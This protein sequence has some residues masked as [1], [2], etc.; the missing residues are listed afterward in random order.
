MLLVHYKFYEC[1]KACKDVLVFLKSSNF[2]YICHN[3]LV[4][5]DVLLT[6]LCGHWKV[7][8]MKDWLFT[9]VFYFKRFKYTIFSYLISICER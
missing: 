3:Y 2:L 1:N 9:K 8:L 7:Y 6:K 5:E 4:I